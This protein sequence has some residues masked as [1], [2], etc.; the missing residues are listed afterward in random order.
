MV[1]EC[2]FVVDYF[3][4][5]WVIILMCVEKVVNTTHKEKWHHLSVG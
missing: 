4:L 2:L 5:M 3:T 1:G